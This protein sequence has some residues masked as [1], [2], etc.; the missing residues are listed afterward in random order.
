MQAGRL[1]QDLFLFLNVF[2]IHCAPLR[3]RVDDIPLLATHLLQWVCKRMGRKIPVVTEGIITQLKQYTW[4]G[5]VRELANVIE[6]S[7]IV[8]QAGKLV[9]DIQNPVAS[10]GH[11]ASV[12]MSEAEIEQIR[13]ANLIACLKETGGRVSGRG[14]AAEL[15]GIRPTT[16]FSRIQKLGLSDKD[17]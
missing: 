5:N 14:G 17:W 10:V 12:L 6:R 1:R 9:I 7:A 11:N 8:S 15:L 16:L 2:P 13:V 3:E 4:P